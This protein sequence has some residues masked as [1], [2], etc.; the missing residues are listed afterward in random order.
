MALQL[1]ADI[2]R[3]RERMEKMTFEETKTREAK[4]L[5]LHVRSLE[6]LFESFKKR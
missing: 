4:E 6:I 1:L 3:L 5:A 2:M